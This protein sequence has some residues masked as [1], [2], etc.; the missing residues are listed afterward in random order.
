[1]TEQRKAVPQQDA[2]TMDEASGYITQAVSAL[3]RLSDQA[4]SELHHAWLQ[5][6][7]ARCE[8]LRVKAGEPIPGFQVMECD[9]CGKTTEHGQVGEISWGCAVCGSIRKP[10]DP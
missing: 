5:L 6:L 7:Q 2:E 9:K 4:R 8:V 10:G 3:E 1:M